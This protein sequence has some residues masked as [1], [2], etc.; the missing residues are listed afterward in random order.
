MNANGALAAELREAGVAAGVTNNLSIKLAP[1][2]SLSEV[3]QA[4]LTLR[5]SNP[6]SFATPVNDKALDGLKFSACLPEWL[7]RRILSQRM[8][9]V[10]A[11]ESVLAERVALT[12]LA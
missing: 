11:I 6:E 7:A 1:E 5:R 2:C 10:A 9:D 4:L 3:E 8:T 12:T